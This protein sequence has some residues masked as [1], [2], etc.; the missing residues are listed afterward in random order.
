MLSVYLR[1]MVAASTLAAFLLPPAPVSAA[2]RVQRTAAFQPGPCTF[3]LPA[4]IEDGRD[5]ECGTLTVPEQHAQ[6]DGPT[7]QL[8]VAIF[9]STGAS[10]APDPLV[11]LQGGPGGSTIDTYSQALLLPHGNRLLEERDVVLFDQRG[12]LY[13]RPSLICTEDIALVERTIEQDL[14]DEE[15]E[16]LSLEASQACR[17]RLAAEGVNLSAFDSLENAAD[18][19]ALRVALGYEQINLYGVSY[20]TLLALHVMREHPEGLRSVILDAV[21][22]TQTNFNAEAPRSQDRAFSEL[23]TACAEQPACNAAFPDLERRLFEQVDRLNAE[24]AR[25]SVTDPE[26]GK[27]YRMVMD[28]DTFLGLMFQ[29][30][31]ASEVLP[32]LPLL[33]D[34]VAR[35]DY[36]FISRIAPLFI[37]DR[38]IAT[39]MYYSTICAEDADFTAQ[40]VDLSQ[41][42]PPFAE[43]AERSA[44]A[45][46]AI[47]RQWDVELLADSVDAPVASDIPT[48]VLNGRFDPITPPAFGEDAAQTLTNS[49]VFT[50]GNTGHGAATADECPASI[51]AQFLAQPSERPDGSCVEAKPAP[52]FFTPATI[53]PTPALNAPLAW[54]EGKNLWQVGALLLSLLLLLSPFLVWPLA[55]VARVLSSRPAA[56][57][58]R[59]IGWARGLAVLAGVLALVFVVGLATTI[60]S[61]AVDNEI[62]LLFGAPRW[63]APLFA[64]PPLLVLLAA[65]LVVAAALGWR[66]SAAWSGWQRGYYA[67]LALAAVGFAAVLGSMGMITALL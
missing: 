32:G 3:E 53:L 64:L 59:F 12:T 26:T 54:F 4:G 13:S 19:E 6:P 48:L 35:G 65:G 9:R 29:L 24:P 47:C 42:R 2:P 57:P 66:G 49:Y 23:F 15:G 58:R 40:D 43:D 28:G 5:V 10:P 62:V 11:M 16:R 37:F 52:E 60:I 20:G 36:S 31:Y 45:I 46:A 8:A 22:P 14:S 34:R 61:T 25:V 39:G 30:L 1:V 51:I 33:V 21:V 38:T 44:E 17:D 67:L 55:W 56:P 18:V 7:I 50:F 41:V 63:A 27:S